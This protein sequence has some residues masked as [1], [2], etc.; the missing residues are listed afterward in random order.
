MKEPDGLQAELSQ[1]LLIVLGDLQANTGNDT[2]EVFLIGSDGLNSLLQ[3][4]E[5]RLLRDRLCWEGAGVGW[6]NLR[7]EMNWKQ[8]KSPPFL[9]IILGTVLDRFRANRSKHGYHICVI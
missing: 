2:L 4:N 5:F 9:K 6:G 3:I 8:E 1:T 7:L